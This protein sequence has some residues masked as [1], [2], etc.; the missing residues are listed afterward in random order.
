MKA[1][2]ISRRLGTAVCALSLAVMLASCASTE[3]SSVTTNQAFAPLSGTLAQYQQLAQNADADSSYPAN[4][5]LARALI[6]SGDYGQAQALLDNLKQQAITPLELDEA[7]M[8]Q[9]LL[10]TQQGQNIEAYHLLEKVNTMTL[11]PQAAS[12]YYQLTSNTELKLYQSSQDNKYLRQAFEHKRILS[13]QLSGQDKITVLNQ[14]VDM[15][16]ELP[17]AELAA[18]L[19][20]T[21]DEES[22][23]FIEYAIIDSS[24]N[25]NLKAQLSASWQEK[26]PGH[27]LTALLSGSSTA[28]AASAAAGSSEPGTAQYAQL[29]E[30]DRV[31]VLLPL[32]GRF[33]ASVGEPARLGVISALQDRNLKLNVVF[34]DTNRL[35]MEEIA[36]RIKSDGT[37]FIIGPILK[38]SVQALLAQ[39]LSL[40]MVLLNHPEQ[41][42]KAN[43]WYFNLGPDY[44][45]ALAASKI[46]L[47]GYARPL[48]ISTGSSK[49]QRSIQGFNQNWQQVQGRSAQLCQVST[50]ALSDLSSCPVAAADAIYLAAGPVESA[51]IKSALPASKPV[52]ITDQSFN[53]VNSSPNEA[54]L[55]GA[56]L[57]DMP[58]LI[59]DSELKNSFMQS[60]P[61][62]DPQAQRIFAAA[63]DSINFALNVN[64]LAQNK[65]DVLHGLS[66]DIQLGQ[67]GLIETAP[68]WLKI[69]FPRLQSATGG[70]SSTA[71]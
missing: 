41:S 8:V 50:N 46:A 26:Y 14:C 33:A 3:R 48:I 43:Q 11:P 45:G 4:L 15:L 19:Q 52:Y 40:P 49:A 9:A 62:A 60:I 55:I 56:N 29:K 38:P 61:K 39:N 23:G 1:K 63:Y 17:P 58:W 68:M 6:V 42:L 24:Q 47:D 65:S 2:A 69:E 37:D 5:L 54:L 31:A 25:A 12:Y 32:S 16:K 7:N 71:P 53:G 13:T 10:Y 30:G 20:R 21:Q 44:E 22:R 51:K 70:A 67:N 36:S 66:G 57:G 64:V 34:Y 28:A 27:P 59:T 18:L 35:T